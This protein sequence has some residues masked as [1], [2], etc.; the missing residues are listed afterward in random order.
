LSQLDMTRL[1]I[2]DTSVLKENQPAC[3]HIPHLVQ[4]KATA[5]AAEQPPC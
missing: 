1:Y 4:H 3:H 5:A 2:A